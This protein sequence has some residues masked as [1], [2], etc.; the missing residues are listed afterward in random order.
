MTC[1][2]NIYTRSL[3]FLFLLLGF[4]FGCIQSSQASPI[5]D[6]SREM[7]E[8]AEELLLNARD[9]WS[10]LLQ[11]QRV[12]SGC[13]DG[14]LGEAYSDAVVHLFAQRWNQFRTFAAL[15]KKDPVFQ[16]WAVR[17]IDASASDED[18]KKIVLNTTTCLGDVEVKNL[19]KTI[20]ELAANSL[21]ESE[22]LR[23]SL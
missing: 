3:V 9:N 20:R 23:R 12:F 10:S 8:K 16:L 15:A 21:A 14:S 11:H 5:G 18:L 19:C 13:D 2:R 1:F 7:N 4:T 17:H 6:C 22:Q